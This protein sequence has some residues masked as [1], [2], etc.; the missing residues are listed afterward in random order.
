MKTTELAELILFYALMTVL[1]QKGMT[2]R[3]H[4]SDYCC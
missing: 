3:M 2:A 1:S 4:R